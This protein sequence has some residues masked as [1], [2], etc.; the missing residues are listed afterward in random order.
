[1]NEAAQLLLGTHDFSCFEKS[2]GDNKT[3]V[4][5]VY[6]AR[7]VP[8]EPVLHAPLSAASSALYWRF[9]IEADRFLRNMV[10]AVVGTLVDVCRGKLSI[11]D[12]KNVVSGHNRS[13]AGESMPANALFLEDVVY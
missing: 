2:G 4:C 11:E 8:Y 12:F 10:R 1:M 7:W 3:S 9:E 6:D 13:D 5:T